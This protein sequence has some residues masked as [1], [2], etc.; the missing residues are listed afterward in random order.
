MMPR[1]RNP[2][3]P[4]TVENPFPFW[5]WL[6]REAPVYEVPGAGYYLV[7]RYDDVRRVAEDSETFSSALAVLAWRD[8]DGNPT[9]E[10]AGTAERSFGRVL[11]VADGE[12]H[13]EQR[14][15]VGR[16]FS[17]ARMA[18]LES[19]AGAIA[20]RCIEGIRPSEVVDFV[21]AIAAPLP[22]EIMT[23]LLG[24][25]LEDEERLQRGANHAIQLM[26]GLL[27]QRE[28]AEGFEIAKELEVYLE[29]CFEEA[30]RNPR[31]DVTGDLARAVRAA[32]LGGE[33]LQRWEAQGVLFQLVVGGIETTVGLIANCIRYAAEIPALWQRLREN[34]ALVPDFIEEV[35]R[36]DP[37]AIGNYRRATRDTELAGVALPKGSTLHLLWGSANRDETQFPEPDR[38]RLD[39]PNNKSHL[40]FG[41]GK[42]FCLG[43]SLARM[44]TRVAVGALLDR[45]EKIDLVD[46]AESLRHKPGLVVRRLERLPA[47][48]S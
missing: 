41:R 35:I 8:P 36:I 30:L 2:V 1:D 4:E 11:G 18:R 15:V 29:G 22:R 27:S 43:A 24:L 38:F 13:A 44:E 28:L 45:F 42:H 6:R 33:G 17:P 12:P 34:P 20:R 46:P 26:S 7:S 31:P 16:T 23:R 37:V 25:P 14:R 48:A 39:R 19:Q 21:E 10:V 47:V 9:L 3:A 40:G 5:A 32:D